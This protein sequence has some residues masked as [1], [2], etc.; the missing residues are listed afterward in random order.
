LGQ[1]LHFLRGSTDYGG[2]AAVLLYHRRRWLASALISL[3]LV[4][5]G[6]KAPLSG[7][8]STQLAIA[9]NLT[10][11][12]GDNCASILC[13]GHAQA[14]AGIPWLCHPHWRGFSAEPDTAYRKE[15]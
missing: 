7:I 11:I 8:Q 4:F 13:R 6:Q 5:F 12:D 1:F 2:L 14:G 3:L 15:Y 10:T 9:Y